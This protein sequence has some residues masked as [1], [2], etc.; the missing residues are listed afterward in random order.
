MTTLLLALVYICFIS[1]GLPDSLLGSSW[2]TVHQQLNLPLSYAG[3]ISSVISLGTILSS[4]VTGKLLQKLG[5]GKLTAISIALTAIGLLGFSFCKG[6]WGFIICA[7]P[8]GLGAG[9]VD[10]ALNNYVALN[11]KS[12][13]MS[14]LHCA[15]GAG[16]S[17]SPYI[18]GLALTGLNDWSKGYLIVFIIQALLSTVIFFTLP[19]WK[20]GEIKRSNDGE[21]EVLESFSLNRILKIPGAI[22]CFIAFFG[23]CALE[24]TASLWASSYLV[25][26]H[27]VTAETASLFASLFYIGIT[28]G[29]A[30]NG[31]LSMKLSDKLLIRSG[32]T[33]ILVGLILLVLPFSSLFALVGFIVIGLGCAPVYPC[34]I[35]MTPSLFG[36]AQS[37]S[38]IGIQMAFAYTG[39]L[40]VPPI[41]G[42]V[43]SAFSIK[44]L[45][46][47][48]LCLLLL[49]FVMHEIVVKKRAKK[50]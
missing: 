4:L 37:R 50:V 45:P 13:H 10:A 11:F 29:R 23:Y 43:A 47:F 22:S 40:I 2:P 9:A 25:K 14:W 21:E 44:L 31:F 1:L 35:H 7:I 27:N 6:F 32:L 17:I 48:L 24:V 34:I 16:A 38:M 8:Y 15:W 39:F 30:I 46:L 20:K 19:V 3:I 5:T 26:V 36:R 42:F 18:M 33:I 49:T 12:Q 41:F 28:L